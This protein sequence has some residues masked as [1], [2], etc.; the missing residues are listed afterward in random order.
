MSVNPV[1]VSTALDL[2]DLGF[3]ENS[4]KFDSLTLEGDRFVCIKDQDG[5]NLTVAIIDMHNGNSVSR[6][7]MKAE[8]AIMNPKEPIIALKAVIDSGYFVQIFHLE[9]KEKIGYHQFE[10]NIVFWK[11]VSQDDLAIVTDNFVYHWNVGKSDPKVMFERSGKLAEQSTKLVGYAS[12][13]QQKWCLIFGIYSLDQGNTVDGAI[14]LYSTERRQQQLFEGYA[15]SFGELRVS[16]DSMAKTGLLV[17]CEHK[18]GGNRTKIHIMDV[19][20]QRDESDT[21]PLKV[22][23]E[24]Q[25]SPGFPSDFPISIHIIDAI[26]LVCVLTKNGFAQFFFA[27]TATF[28]FS[29]R[30]SES[31]LF[32]SCDKKV[33]DKTVGA[34][35]V[36]RLGKIIEISVD[37]E[38][39]LQ[40]VAHL[41]D[42]SV[43]LAT[44]YGLKGSDELLVKSFE[45]YFANKQYKQAALIVATLKSDE[46]RNAATIERFKNAPSVPGQPSPASHY[47]S[48]LL[49]HGKLNTLESLELTRPVVTQGRKELVKKWL[50]EEKLTESPELGDLLRQLDTALAFKVYTRI[51]DHLKAIMC[52][53]EAGQVNKVVP[54]IK[55]IA[56]TTNV[57]YTT[58]SCGDKVALVEGLPSIFLIIENVISRHPGE[59]VSFISDLIAG[60]G[61]NEPLCDMVQVTELL[62]RLNKLQELTSILLDYLK[63]NLPQHAS[64]QTRLLEVNLQNEPKIAETILQLDVLTHFDKPFI[65][66]LCEDAGLYDVALQYY[67]NAS[68]LKRIVVKSSG[69][70]TPSVLE[71]ALSSMAGDLAFEILRDMVDGGA[72]IDLVVSSALSLEKKIGPLKL[73]EMFE[74]AGASYALFSFLRALPIMS[75]KGDANSEEDAQLVYKF[76]ECAISQNEVADLERVCRDSNCYDLSNVKDLLKRSRLSNP[77]SLMIVCDRLGSIAEMTEYLYQSGLD[78]YLEV[79][80]NTINPGSI[81]S[82]VGTLFD[83]GAPDNLIFSIL[84]NLRDSNGIKAMIDV[85]DERHQLMMLRNWLETRVSEGHREPEIHTALAKIYISSHNNAEEFL[86]TNK[87]YDRKVVGKFCEDHDP[88]LA[89]FIYAEAQFDDQ[90]AKLCLTNGMHRQLASYG[91]GRQSLAFWKTVLVSGDIAKDQDV[92]RLCEEVIGLAAESTNTSEISCIIKAFMECDMNEQLISILEQLLLTQTQFSSNANLQNLLLATTIKTNPEKLEEYLV[93]LENYEVDSLAKMANDLGLYRSS[94]LILKKSGRHLEALNALLKLENVLGEAEAYANEVNKSNVWFTLARAYMDKKMQNEAIN[95]YLKSENINDHALIKREVKDPQ[96]FSR[97]LKESRKLKDSREIDTDLLFHLA[98]MGDSEEFTSLLNG[99]HHADLNQVGDSLIECKLYKEAVKLYNMIP[100]HA[101]LAVCYVNMENYEGASNSALKSRNP[102]VLKHVFDV[103]LDKGQVEMANKVGLD[104]ILYPEFLPGLVSAYESYGHVD[105]LITLLGNAT[106]SVAVSTELAIAIAKY[107]PERLMDHLKAV[108]FESDSIN[109]AKTARECSNLWLWKE[110]IFLYTI[111][112]SDKALLSMIVHAALAWDQET[113]FSCAKN[114]SNTEVLYKALHFCIQQRPMLIPQLLTCVKTKLDTERLLKILKNANCLCLARQFL[115]TAADRTLAIVND[116]LFELYVEENEWELLD[117]AIT[118][119]DAYDHAKLCA[120]LENHGLSKMRAIG[121]KVY[122]KDRNYAKACQ[123]HRKNG[124][125]KAAMD[126]ARTSK[127][128]SV[129]LDLLK[130]F[131]SKSMLE[132]FIACLTINFSLVEPAEALELAWLSGMNLDPIM[133]FIIQTLRFT[134]SSKNNSQDKNKHLYLTYK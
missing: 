99:K 115:E 71:K 17:F 134:P 88:Q 92:N 57:S 78:S 126:T 30:I 22:S 80:V 64:L 33:G 11:W 111:E 67:S 31:A 69:T 65:A 130:Y 62:I 28:L 39:L 19:Y 101:K 23:S 125:Y 123:I 1:K 43:G 51:G 106:K 49:E 109:I 113:F 42:V 7:P 112:D 97:W 48:V 84:N 128:E 35:A 86:K 76:I 18:R 54:Y 3:S 58:S 89:F 46:L 26:G 74:D 110:A 47:F 83:L 24:M 21:P 91:L 60:L 6:K 96:L 16:P 118:R 87:L 81:S 127:S 2:K 55:K 124:N 70:I 37:E 5:A 95:A 40:S 50:D 13:K 132:E 29:E 107:R 68:D 105:D 45:N 121:A 98:K 85:A 79:Y 100:N 41:D 129:V 10:E 59:I 108:A 25:K 56:S 102:R 32:V 12:D 34:L 27:A 75:Q 15:G 4:F 114:V 72:N 73:V 133:P 116:S 82:V 20:T 131:I 53:V 103:C 36:N 44:C 77:K 63:P 52:L 117:K 66:R 8:A 119:Y 90:M 93:K 104:L 9:T 122:Q 94:F 14:Q 120:S 61:K 38:R